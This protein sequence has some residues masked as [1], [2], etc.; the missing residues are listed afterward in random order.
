M[1]GSIVEYLYNTTFIFLGSCS[2]G[3]SFR[4]ITISGGIGCSIACLATDSLLS[5]RIVITFDRFV[6]H[7]LHLECQFTICTLGGS[8]I[9][10]CHFRRSVSACIISSIACF[11]LR[12]FRSR[13]R[14][15]RIASFCLVGRS[16]VIIF[17]TRYIPGYLPAFILVIVRCFFRRTFVLYILLRF[18]FRLIFGKTNRSV[19]ICTACLT[20]L[21][22]QNFHLQFEVFYLLFELLYDRFCFQ[23]LFGRLFDEFFSDT[24]LKLT[25]CHIS[26]VFRRAVFRAIDFPAKTETCE[27]CS[28]VSA[29]YDRRI[30][31]IGRVET[32][33]N[34]SQ[35]RK[36]TAC[37][38]LQCSTDRNGKGF[39]FG[40]HYVQ[41]IVLEAVVRKQAV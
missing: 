28:V 13:F 35:H 8:S 27:Y 4:I 31:I 24:R 20:Y 12:S 15:C 37:I 22:F 30:V 34:V 5:C 40:R 10:A 6:S 23:S 7:Q 39:R 17:N 41:L 16:Y 14:V 19:S 32:I 38:P 3:C 29:T 25:H 2:C 26:V 11:R 9:F 1:L 36:P 18:F 33:L 21:V